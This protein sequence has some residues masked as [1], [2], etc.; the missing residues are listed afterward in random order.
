M[1]PWLSEIL[2]CP[3]DKHYPLNLVIFKIEDLDGFLKKA[4]NMEEMQKDLT[5]FFKN[6]GEERDTGT[7]LRVINFDDASGQLLLFDTLVRK[8]SPSAVYLERIVSSIDE[9]QPIRDI[10]HESVKSTI[11]KLLAFKGTVIKA[12]DAVKKAGTDAEAQKKLIKEIEPTL[13][14]LNWFKQAV[15]IEAGVMTC[16][17]C[18]R[19][20]PIRESIPQMLPDELRRE[21]YDKEFL[22]AWKEKL[23][24]A[25]VTQGIP[26]HL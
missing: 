1:K 24:Q 2:A 7:D 14:S 25:I 19:W 22:V 13:V 11:T 23:D 9:L 8:P 16:D 15:E 5:F 6:A 17:K 3:L 18:N 12:L 4:G 10:S 21:K 20:Y 26:Y